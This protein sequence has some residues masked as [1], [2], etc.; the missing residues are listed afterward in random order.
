MSPIALSRCR[1]PAGFD[2]DDDEF[3]IDPYDWQVRTFCDTQQFYSRWYTPEEIEEYWMA[4]CYT[5]KEELALCW[6]Q[7]AVRPCVGVSRP[8]LKDIPGDGDIIHHVSMWRRER[9]HSRAQQ[10]QA[11][12]AIEKT[13]HHQ[14]NLNA[15]WTAS[16][17]SIPAPMVD[18]PGDD[19]F[20]C[21]CT[22]YI[23]K[24]AFG[25]D[26]RRLQISLTRDAGISDVRLIND[27]VKDGFAS[28]LA[29]EGFTLE[30]EGVDGCMHSLDQTKL[31]EFSNLIR[32]A[33][34]N[35]VKLNV[36]QIGSG[37]TASSDRAM[38]KMQTFSIATPPLTPR[39][40]SDIP[41]EWSLS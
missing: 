35:V 36:K 19:V 32:T 11:E 29:D 7:H 23:L 30:F 34:G 31:D 28:Q 16:E 13:P 1:H 39:P 37:A 41:P 9:A 40:M 10:Q 27:F 17:D 33:H 3:R 12:R 25:C 8:L 26:I 4:Q 20:S 18:E 38:G 6:Q 15:G 2:E 14:T 5:Q 24:V 21:E 22:Q